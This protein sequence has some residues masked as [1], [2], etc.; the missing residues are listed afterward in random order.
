LVQ[1]PQ[2][3]NGGICQRLQHDGLTLNRQYIGK[4]V[5]EIHTERA[6][7]PVVLMK[8]VH[9][10]RNRLQVVAPS[11]KTARCYS[12]EQAASQLPGQVF[13]LGVESHDDLCDGPSYLLQGLADQGL[14]RGMSNRRHLIDE[15]VHILVRR[16]VLALLLKVRSEESA[17]ARDDRRQ[18][19]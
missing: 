5:S 12:L 17:R 2:V 14:F 11:S 18:D 3:R 10:K 7:V 1:T 16:Q 15:C 9:D 13:H 8:P 4:L 6:M 19:Y